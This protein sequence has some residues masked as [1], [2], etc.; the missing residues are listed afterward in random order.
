MRINNG[1]PYHYLTWLDRSSYQR[2]SKRK[3]FLRNFA[4]LTENTCARVSLKKRLWHRCFPV[5]FTKFLRTPFLRNTSGRLL[6]T[7]ISFCGT[8]WNSFLMNRFLITFAITPLSTDIK[9]NLNGYLKHFL[10]LKILG[11]LLYF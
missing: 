8:W 6:L 7:G 3:S 2:C 11:C 4:K 9:G 5:N 1:K 10:S